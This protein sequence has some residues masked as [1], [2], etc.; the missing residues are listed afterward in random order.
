MK[1]VKNDPANNIDTATK[2]G[3]MTEQIANWAVE[4]ENLH[5]CKEDKNFKARYNAAKKKIDNA[6]R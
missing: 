1:K 6:N 4:W 5:D 2:I 3:S